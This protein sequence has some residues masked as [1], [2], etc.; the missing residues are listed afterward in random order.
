MGKIMDRWSKKALAQILFLISGVL[1]ILSLINYYSVIYVDI[2][3]IIPISVKR[4]GYFCEWPL[5]MILAFLFLR[6]PYKS[7]KLFDRCY[8]SDKEMKYYK[9]QAIML[10]INSIIELIAS[11]GAV[12]FCSWY[13]WETLI[14]ANFN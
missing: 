6:V 9:W 2:T 8:K 4:V 5:W 12:C 11:I 7:D 3:G 1:L 14:G 13:Y 10:S